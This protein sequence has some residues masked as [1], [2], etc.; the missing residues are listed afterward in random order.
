MNKF[1]IGDRIE[2]RIKRS[3]LLDITHG[4]VVFLPDD[5]SILVR[6]SNGNEGKDDASN[7]HISVR[8]N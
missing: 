2:S 4:T 3:G 6:W 1:K 5:F 8:K 7:P